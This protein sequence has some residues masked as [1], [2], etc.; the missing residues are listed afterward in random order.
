MNCPICE[1]ALSL[2]PEGFYNC[3]NSSHAKNGHTY[4]RMTKGKIVI[5]SYIHRGWRINTTTLIPA[6]GTPLTSCYR[7]DYA[8][9]FLDSDYSKF[10]YEVR[11]YMPP[12]A[13]E[14]TIDLINRVPVSLEIKSPLN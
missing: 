1:K 4:V 2:H 9:P 11:A 8:N 10:D 13:L 6:M 14:D 5:E 12:E 3:P 7:F